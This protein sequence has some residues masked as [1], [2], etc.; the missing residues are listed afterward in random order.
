MLPH[1][2]N[3]FRRSQT[4]GKGAGMKGI[5]R[6]QAEFCCCSSCLL[7]NGLPDAPASI[8]GS[9]SRRVG[10]SNEGSQTLP[11]H[12]TWRLRGRT[13]SKHHSSGL[14]TG[15]LKGGAVFKRL[16]GRRWPPGT[17]HGSGEV[18]WVHQ[19]TRGASH[20]APRARLRGRICSESPDP[21]PPR[22]C[23]HAS[24]HQVAIGGRFLVKPSPL[25]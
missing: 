2:V 5:F 11:G 18:W 6:S 20:A 25:R 21:A 19:P 8:F 15:G 22:H 24:R 3:L 13:C 16:D 1:S 7:C 14:C 10:R 23:T 4:R 12:G 17:F 9:R